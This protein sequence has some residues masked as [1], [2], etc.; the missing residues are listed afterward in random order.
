MAIIR[1]H[2]YSI[3]THTFSQADFCCAYGVDGIKLTYGYDC[4]MLPLVTA[5]PTAGTIKLADT[6]CGRSGG[7]GT[8]TSGTTS[9]TVCCK[10]MDLSWA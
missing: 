1:I 4:L 3:K 5:S 2:N 9:K 7:I 6:L 10:F 8:S